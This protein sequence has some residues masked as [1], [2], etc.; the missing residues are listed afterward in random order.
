MRIACW[1]PQA[2]ALSPAQRVA[3]LAAA[4]RRA[5]AAGADLLVAPELVLSGYPASPADLA[6]AGAPLVEAAGLVAREARIGL[7]VG[8]P[9]QTA[10]GLADTVRAFAADGSTAAVYRKTHLYGSLEKSVFVP[11]GTAVAQFRAGGL[12]AGLGVCYDVEFP[13]FV[14]EHALRGTELLV[15]PAALAEPWGFVPEVLV[16]ARAFESQLHVAYVNWAPD[17][18]PGGPRFAGRSTVVAPDG[19]ATVLAQD[20]ELAV[21]RVEAGAVVEARA[22]TTYLRDRRPALYGAAEEPWTG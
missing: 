3:R 4:A 6:A 22:S 2:L 16:R 15:V 5:A 10:R 13:E 17:P 19:T 1:Q 9:E 7:V 18:A 12:T 21:I 8:Y 14:R 20:E 11:G